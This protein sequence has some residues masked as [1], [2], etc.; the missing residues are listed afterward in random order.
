MIKNGRDQSI[1]FK[2]ARWL[3]EAHPPPPF[4]GGLISWYQHYIIQV[5][6]FP[7]ISISNYV[8]I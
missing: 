3:G 5:L 7:Y 2:G 1:L 6:H 8:L 4:L